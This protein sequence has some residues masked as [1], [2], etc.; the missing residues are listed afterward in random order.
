MI[1]HI[2]ERTAVYNGVKE[3]RPHDGTRTFLQTE[4]DVRIDV[5]VAYARKKP[6]S[7]I[8]LFHGNKSTINVE[9]NGPVEMILTNLTSNVVVF[10]YRGFGRSEGTT[11]EEGI[12]HDVKAVMTYVLKTVRSENHPIIFYGRSIGCAVALR[13]IMSYPD[14]KGLILENPFLSIVSYVPT[15]FFRYVSSFFINDLWNN[16]EEIKKVTGKKVAVVVSTMDKVTPKE[17]GVQ[18]YELCKCKEKDMWVF[19]NA[20]MASGK[21]EVFFHKMANFILE[22]IKR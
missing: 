18:L 3:E 7:T 20:H 11:T 17:H 1:K 5:C 10:D 15:P 9:M 22:L 19:N 16:E 8:V 21:D 13:T 4:D 12:M 2:V 6:N 14:V